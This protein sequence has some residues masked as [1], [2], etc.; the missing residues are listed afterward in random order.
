MLKVNEVRIIKID[1]G[2][3]LGYAS[4]KIDNSFIVEGIELRDGKNGR[5]ILMP[6]SSRKRK[7]KRNNAYPIND[8]TR[9]H[10]LDLISEEYDKTE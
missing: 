6:L 3:F 7:T 8:D 5:Y 2:N 4:I 9:K 10:L 1:K